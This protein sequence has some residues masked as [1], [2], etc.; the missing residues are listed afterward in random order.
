MLADKQQIPISL[1]TS[2]LSLALETRICHY[3]EL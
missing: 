1:S 3:F 2:G